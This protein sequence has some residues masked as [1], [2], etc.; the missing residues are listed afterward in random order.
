MIS[1]VDTVCRVGRVQ[2]VTF[3]NVADA[4]NSLQLTRVDYK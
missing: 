4:L 2:H 1:R 3:P